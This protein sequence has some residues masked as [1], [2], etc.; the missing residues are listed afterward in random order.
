M[1]LLIRGKVDAYLG[2]LTMNS[3]EWEI[4]GRTDVA[5]ARIQPVYPLSE[6]LTQLWMR[7]AMRRP[8]PRGQAEYPMPCPRRFGRNT[9]CCPCNA[10]CGAF[11]CQIATSIWKRHGAGCP[12]RRCSIFSW[13]CCARS[14][15]G[16]LNPVGNS[17]RRLNVSRRSRGRSCSP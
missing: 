13:D 1:H 3:P 10:L 4:V 9:T 5:S 12:L 2:R 14:A 15:S 16:S 7:A 8:S 6:G 17:Q 11:I